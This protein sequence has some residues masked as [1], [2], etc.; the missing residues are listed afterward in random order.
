[1]EKSVEDAQERSE[2]HVKEIVIDFFDPEQGKA[3][4]S[5]GS[6][7]QEFDAMLVA[8]FDPD[9]RASILSKFDDQ[10]GN[11]FGLKIKEI[12]QILDWN[13]EDGAL[14]K[15]R[16]TFI[17]DV[18][19]SM[20]PIQRQIND[21]LERIGAKKGAQAERK[22]SSHKG[23][24]F[25][26]YMDELVQAQAGMFSDFAQ[27]TDAIPSESGSKV[28][29]EVVEIRK[30]NSGGRD[31]RIVWEFK[32]EAGKQ[33]QTSAKKL[34]EELDEAMEN[35][36]AQV[37]VGVYDLNEMTKEMRRFKE[38][39]SNKAVIVIDNSEEGD[40][41]VNAIIVQ[42]AYV[43]AR[44]AALRELTDSDDHVNYKQLQAIINSMTDDVSNISQIKSGHT[45]IATGLKQSEMW[46]KTLE[47]S[48]KPKINDLIELVEPS[49]M[50]NKNS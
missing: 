40:D 19:K 16:E 30:D 31:R 11:T 24:D 48:I 21:V 25:N 8:K 4:K 14:K 37:A 36:K 9:S 47:E 15:L 33:K 27:F 49:K 46:L 10:I 44:W 13:T 23:G 50:G 12:N 34:L 18:N 45:R 7:R 1:L 38:F 2:K 28:G 41:E 3:A 26:K 6:F 29:D 5:L 43:W 32:T 22:N 20:E 35:R 42:M 39:G 17:E